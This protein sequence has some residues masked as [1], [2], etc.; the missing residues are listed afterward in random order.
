[1][2]NLKLMKQINI[3]F[4]PGNVKKYLNN[5]MFEKPTDEWNPIFV[6]LKK[7]LDSKNINLNTF[8][9]QR[10]KH[11]DIYLFHDVP[12]IWNFWAISV[13]K[14]I[15]KH[16]N[17]N[18]LIT[19]ET[20]TIIPYEYYKLF[21]IFFRKIYTWN[22]DWVD[23]K[24]Y[25]KFII[26]KLNNG[27]NTKQKKFSNKNFLVVINANKLPNPILEFFNPLGRELFHDRI[28]AIEFFEKKIP[29]RF[30]LYGRGWNKPRKYSFL[31]PIFG[32]KKFKSY[33]GEIGMDDKMEVLSNYKYCL[34]F[35][36][37]TN[38]N[39]YITEKIFDCFKAK[40]VPIYWGASNI[41]QYIPKECFIDFRE[42]KYDYQKLLKYLDS[43]DEDR[44]NQYIKSIKKLMRNK[45]FLDTWFNGFNKFFVEDLIK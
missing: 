7:Y 1:M 45:R 26:P 25:F 10:N 18:I 36:N 6:K 34:C 43:V 28:K 20:P 30:F 23:N 16:R 27:W 29:E 2:Y 44:Y 41:E 38:V 24:K 3:S 14:L 32:Y 15:F 13:W 39:G 40:V 19:H 42:F 12:Y 31:E 35:E 21:H 11:T 33:Q 5:K 17:K 37:L 9:V 22:D 4:F 8:D